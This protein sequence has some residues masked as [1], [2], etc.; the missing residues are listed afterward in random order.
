M[1]TLYQYS[2]FKVFTRIGVAKTM[3]FAVAALCSAAPRESWA[4]EATAQP[5]ASNARVTADS[6]AGGR[7]RVIVSTDIG[8]TDPDDFQSMVHL[9][10]YA[11][12][13][14]IEGLISSPFGEGR[15]KDILDVIDCYEKDYANLKSYSDNYP[16]PAALRTITRQGETER[17]PFAGVRKSTEGSNWIIECARR[18]DP[19]PLNV[20]V[21]GL[22]EDVA[23]A[24]HDAPD[25]LPKLRIFWIGGP[26][27]K[28]SPDAYQYIATNHPQLWIIESNATYRGW[29]TGGNQKGEWDNQRF[30]SEHLKGKG[31]LGDFF[32]SKKADVKMGD[33]PSVGWL[34]KGSADDPAKPSWGGSYVRAWERPYLC[35]NRL[36]T[37]HDR[38]EAFGILEFALPIS[39]VS[40]QPE[41][42]LIVEN[43][44]LTGHLA[45]DGTMRFRFCP[46]GAK[47]YSFRIESNVRRLDGNRGAITAYIPSPNVANHPSTRLP[48]WWT[49]DLASDVA[50]GSHSGA[51]TVSRWREDYLRDFANRM[52]RCSRKKEL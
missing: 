20:L 28:W 51:K 27:K 10:V 36:P 38:I 42:Y 48:N 1:N 25:I 7:H 52:L 45:D 9:L 12:V 6:L 5:Q 41:A 33:T 13:L 18:D 35:L 2:E 32:V 49:D 23:Q 17:A 8:G 40:Q 16:A 24:L 31:T 44:K 15:T 19:R 43:Q 26:N 22:L 39:D 4:M 37:K 21:W 3:L 46:K 47:S 50:E 14:D 30:V 11:D 34:L 29:F